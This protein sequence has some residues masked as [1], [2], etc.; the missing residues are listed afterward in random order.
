M[1]D[2]ELADIRDR[3]AKATR[4]PWSSKDVQFCEGLEV[5]MFGP[6]GTV[7]FTSNISEN[8]DAFIAH[9]REDVP[10]LL[11]EVER[12]RACLAERIESERIAAALHDY[13]SDLCPVCGGSEFYT[14]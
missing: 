3:E 13:H 10:A 6:D 12:L 8:D 2:A 14:W 5:Q 9:A 7:F 1:T 11:A 4:G